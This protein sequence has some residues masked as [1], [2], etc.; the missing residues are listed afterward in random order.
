[1]ATTQQKVLIVLGSPRRRGNSAALAE[2]VATGAAGAGAAV[3]SIF[4]QKLDIKACTACEGC[5][6]KNARGCVIRDDMQALYPKIRAA[7]AIVLAGPVYWFSVSAQTKLFMDRWYALGGNRDYRGLRGKR[8]GI[9]LAFADADA[10]S[11]GAVNALHT[12]QDAIGYLGGSIE[13]MVYG[14]A[15]VAGEIRKRKDLMHQ[16]AELGKKLAAPA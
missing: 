15:G 10:F 3:E 9:V 7:D 4:L 6:K 16:A 5:R 11:S 8:F 12:F 14:S 2:K 1:M 13:G